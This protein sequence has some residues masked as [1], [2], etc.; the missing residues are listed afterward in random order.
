M[1]TPLWGNYP[2]YL[3]NNW[4][5]STRDPLIDIWRDTFCFIIDAFYLNRRYWFVINF[6]SVIVWVLM[7]RLREMQSAV[8]KYEID[9]TDEKYSS[10]H[11][12]SA[13]IFVAI[14]IQLVCND[15]AIKRARTSGKNR[16]LNTHIIFYVQIIEWINIGCVSAEVFRWLSIDK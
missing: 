15:F 13:L 4:K 3:K 7:K 8:N 16:F 9:K 12:I 2:F 6:V 1:S 5:N 14:Y 10:M 11:W